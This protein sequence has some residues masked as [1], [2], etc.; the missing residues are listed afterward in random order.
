M[1][2]FDED[3]DVCIV[4]D[5]DIW[6][7]D[8]EPKEAQAVAAILG[9]ETELNATCMTFPFAWPG[10]GNVTTST[11]EYTQMMLD[12]YQEHGIICRENADD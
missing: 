10:L 2:Y 12:A 6:P 11:R 8:K 4:L 3:N 1:I 5:E 7:E 9:V